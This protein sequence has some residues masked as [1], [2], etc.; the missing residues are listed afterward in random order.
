MP[1]HSE[2]DPQ[3][4]KKLVP[5]LQVAGIPEVNSERDDQ[6]S[7]RSHQAAPPSGQGMEEACFP[8]G[9]GIKAS[10]SQSG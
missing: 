1:Q 10:S 6:V 3:L 8:A 4:P 7:F 9:Q 2:R 5:K